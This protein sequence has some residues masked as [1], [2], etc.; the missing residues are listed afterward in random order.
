M[1]YS[2]SA[3]WIRPVSAVLLVA[4][5]AARGSG[6]E[7]RPFNVLLLMT[8][9]HHAG[10]LGCAG[11]AVVRTPNLDGLT[12]GGTRFVDS[13]CPV[14]YCSPTR[15]AIVSGRYPSSLG[16]GRNIDPEIT[17]EDPL[18][19]RDS[20]E[21]Y[22]HRL[23]ARGYHCHQLGKWHIGDPAEL[24]CF[25]NAE[26]DRQALAGLAKQ[27]NQAAG[28]N[29]F[30]EG[31]RPGEAERVGS[32][33]LTTVLADAHRRAREQKLW[34][35]QDVGIIG[36]SMV[37][38]EYSYESMLA[39]YCIELL[40]RHRNEPF[41]I[42]YSV[43]PPHAPC[44]A[45]LPFFD[46]YDPARLPLPA[47]WDDRPEAWRN[48]PSCR[49]T[50]IYGEAGFRDWLRCYYAQVSMMDWCI[51]RIL[52]SLDDLGLADRTLVIFT[53]DHGTM[54]GQHGTMDKATGAFYDD[55]MRVPLIMRL[56]GQIPAGKA[57][58]GNASSVDLGPTILDYLAAGPLAKPQGRSLRPLIEGGL[59]DG[60][61][62]F[63]E[64]GDV[65]KPGVAR[66]I[67]TRHWKLCLFPAKRRELYDLEKDPDE[68]HDLSRDPAMASVIGKLSDQL[69]EHM[70]SI[71]DPA[72]ARFAA[73]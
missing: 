67:R 44:V 38:P 71:G 45:P 2:T 41:A 31:R 52:K 68:I 14:P 4:V 69:L 57:C 6:A 59:D 20:C 17:R 39:D 16:I 62:A 35:A 36:R 46:M 26:Q 60:R 24:S 10:A 37:K 5:F 55:L 8:D 63:G 58:A 34:K 49:M 7:R 9:Q 12:A 23:A 54:L 27:R 13:F 66:M 72:M 29:R 40:R 47:T 48:F 70:R 25:P 11:N 3:K 42:T 1:R 30:D 28:K 33:Y 32:V 65:E 22:I 53:S 56:P 21:T 64:R 73:R 50:A 43:S 51:G 19:L 61:P 15:A 18:R